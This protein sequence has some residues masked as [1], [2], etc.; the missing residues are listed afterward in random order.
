M[1][2]RHHHH[3]FTQEWF[4]ESRPWLLRVF[5]APLVGRWLRRKMGVRLDGK[6]VD[7]RPECII[8]QVGERD[9]QYVGWA[10]DAVSQFVYE[11]AKP[12][13]WAIHY[14]DEF[15]ADRWIPE[16]SY[17]F[18]TLDGVTG[19]NLAG[20]PTLRRFTSED[21]VT[22]RAFDISIQ[23][24]ASSWTIARNGTGVDL[25]VISSLSNPTALQ[26]SV[27]FQS[28][29]PALTSIFRTF[30]HFDTS[31]MAGDRGQNIPGTVAVTWA[32]VIVVPAPF[33]F[34]PF[35]VVLCQ[36]TINPTKTTS[37]VV[38]ADFRQT[39]VTS[40]IDLATTRE[41]G[42][43]SGGARDENNNYMQLVP[44]QPANQAPLLYQWIIKSGDPS[45]LGEID[46]YYYPPSIRQIG[47]HNGLARFCLRQ[48][49]EFF[50]NAPSNGYDSVNAIQ[51]RETAN[52]IFY[53]PRLVANYT[54][55]LVIDAFSVE[56]G[57]KFGTPEVQSLQDVRLVSI[58]R[59]FPVEQTRFG[60]PE[61]ISSVPPVE[62]RGFQN[63]IRLGLPIVPLVITQ[64]FQD[65]ATFGSPSVLTSVN[66]TGFANTTTFGLPVFNRDTAQTIRSTGFVNSFNFGLPF[67]QST[68]YLIR[69]QSIL[70]T[71]R[72]GARWYVGH[73]FPEEVYV[74]RLQDLPLQYQ[75]IT[76]EYDGGRVETNVQVCGVRQWRL[77]YDG[78]SEEDVAILVA[79]FNK[80]QGRVGL[81]PFY[82][83]RDDVVYDDCR[84]VAFD[85]P[86]RIKKWSNAVSITIEREE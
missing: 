63:L 80:V 71:T 8:I 47:S 16:L 75:T 36:S 28:T 5:N 49:T 7:I 15:V 26:T 59:S 23:S 2:R 14:W 6:I 9:Y 22:T 85:L 33:T 24:D 13:W 58:P 67:V 61:I 52:P 44:G 65:T 11:V 48:E 77:E 76:H 18:S 31:A 83:R 79:H 35:P 10:G 39:P 78:L 64:G 17:G 43:R 86:A 57:A 84:Y 81:F 34:N 60:R 29:A 66:L 40:P 42:N 70:P 73:A 3:A 74:S 21:T 51:S 25:Y 62:A 32:S 56:P 46:S 37:Q 30:L 1:R 12:L 55:G 82:H 27:F 4:R 38:G 54:V 20:P 19:G 53:T 50:A 68:E 45:L 69:A 72:F 41:A